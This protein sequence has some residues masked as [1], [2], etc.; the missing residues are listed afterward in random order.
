MAFFGLIVQFEQAFSVV[1]VQFLEEDRQ[2]DVLGSS[3]HEPETKKGWILV[4]Q[5]N[6]SLLSN[7]EAP[8]SKKSSREHSKGNILT[9]LNEILKRGISTGTKRNYCKRCHRNFTDSS[10]V[11]QHLHV[12][13]QSISIFLQHVFYT[14][15]ILKST[16]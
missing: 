16:F 2:R 15:S 14:T 10:T 11:E 7:N 9:I 4:A 5:G 12:L 13:R 6:D 8:S 3:P 1:A